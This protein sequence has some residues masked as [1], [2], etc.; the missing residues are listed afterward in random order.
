[1]LD[2]SRALVDFSS[3]HRARGNRVCHAFGLPAIAAAVLGALAH[4]P[5]PGTPLDAGILLLVATLLLDV[6]LNVRI[7]F[8]VFVLGGLLYVA[9]RPLPP[10]AL[11][12]LFAVGWVLQLVGHRVYEKRAPAFVTNAVHLFVGPRWLVNKLVRALPEQDDERAQ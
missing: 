5:I 4:V 12:L 10:W 11:A 2:L 3:H 8:G 1:M 7:A 6:F 9:A